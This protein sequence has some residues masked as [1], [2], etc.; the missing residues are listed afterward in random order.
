M[1]EFLRAQLAA[2]PTRAIGYFT[3]AVLAVVTWGSKQAGV[4]IPSDVSVAILAVATFI[5]TEAIRRFV[6]APATVAALQTE[7]DKTVEGLLAAEAAPAIPPTDEAVPDDGP[8]DG[9]AGGL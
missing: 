2:N 3:G 4:E 5:A 1:I 7:H 6:Y 8:V 9:V